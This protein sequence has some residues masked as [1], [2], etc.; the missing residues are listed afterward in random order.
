MRTATLFIVLL[1]LCAPNRAAACW[2]SPRE[3]SYVSEN[4]HHKVAVSVADRKR[5]TPSQIAVFDR[6]G[7]EW[8]QSW[9]VSAVNSVRAARLYLDDT[10]S[11]VVTV[12]NWYGYDEG[13][14]ELVVYRRGALL[15]QYSV[16]ELLGASF[17]PGF[18]STAGAEW[19]TD[20]YAFFG[21]EQHFCLWVDVVPRWVTV[22]IKDG[23][24]IDPDIRLVARFEQQI[25][26]ATYASIKSGD[27]NLYNYRRL[28]RFLCPEDKPVFERLL[29]HPDKHLSCGSEDGPS[30]FCYFGSNHHRRLAEMALNA[31]ENG[32]TDAIV[33]FD[34]DKDYKHLGSLRLSATF[35]EAPRKGQGII[36]LWLEPVDNADRVVLR[37][38]P[39]HSMGIKLSVRC[40]FFEWLRREPLPMPIAMTMYGVAPGEYRIHGYWSKTIKDVYDINEDFWKHEGD[41]SIVNIP[42]V[43]IRKGALS[44]TAVS[45]ERKSDSNQVDAGDG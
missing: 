17:R 20:S 6:H 21:P 37:E 38:R 33:E 19:L 15:E 34:E 42:E 9:T 45:F 1:A 13:N 28:A 43:E 35:D 8:V 4:G 18:Y 44:N 27:G 12:G 11:C 41:R 3:G 29:T 36:V 24:L 22:D 7:D 31:L 23:S 39:A 40:S 32:K 14:D 26:E 2:A 16:A 30:G 10:G 5:G 25:R